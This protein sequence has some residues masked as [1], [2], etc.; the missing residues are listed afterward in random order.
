MNRNLF[1]KII[2]N[3]NDSELLWFTRENKL[4][5]NQIDEIYNLALNNNYY[6]TLFFL[7]KTS[8]KEEK[9]TCINKMILSCDPNVL[10]RIY[11]ISD[12]K[13]EIFKKILETKDCNIILQVLN[14]MHQVKKDNP[15]F[16]KQAEKIFLE[17]ATAKELCTFSNLPH[18]NKVKLLKR[19]SEIDTDEKNIKFINNTKASLEEETVDLYLEKG[20]VNVALTDDFFEDIVLERMLSDIK[21]YD[22]ALTV[23]YN[24]LISG[25]IYDKECLVLD[26]KYKEL[27]TKK[28]RKR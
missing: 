11:D 1:I 13:D 16:I 26:D 2:N 24:Y 15:S 4:T 21:K 19:A 5:F 27:T 3:L 8:K 22:I 9:Q 7:L 28:T 14:N 17:Y 25:Y 18:T 23:Y 20:L 10:R 6:E 12:N